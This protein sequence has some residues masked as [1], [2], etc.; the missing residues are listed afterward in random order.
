VLEGLKIRGIHSARWFDLTTKG[1]PRTRRPNLAGFS[2]P[3]AG[4]GLL[5][6]TRRIAMLLANSRKSGGPLPLEPS[7]KV[8]RDVH[9]QRSGFVVAP[10]VEGLNARGPLRVHPKC[11]LGGISAAAEAMM[12]LSREFG[13][14]ALLSAMLIGNQRTAT[15]VSA[16]RI[17][18]SMFP[19]TP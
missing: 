15:I 19:T 4:R 1:R 2:V 3:F 7:F 14:S 6:W 16:L 9:S 13:V 5:L 17:T 8:K 10:G 12:V 11:R 18:G